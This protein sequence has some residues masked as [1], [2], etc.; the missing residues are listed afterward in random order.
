MLKTILH[1]ASDVLKSK[2]KPEK[3]M[4]AVTGAAKVVD[5]IDSKRRKEE[6]EKEKKR[7]EKKLQ[8]RVGY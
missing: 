5:K 6:R 4:K 2:T 7:K 8:Q 3:I 1:T